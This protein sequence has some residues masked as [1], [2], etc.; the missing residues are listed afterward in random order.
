MIEFLVFLQMA[1][2]AYKLARENGT[3]YVGVED[4]GVVQLAIFIGVGR[5]AWR[6]SE[7]ALQELDV[8]YR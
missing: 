8:R 7:R 3:A 4:K 1:W 5:E 6:I 2:R